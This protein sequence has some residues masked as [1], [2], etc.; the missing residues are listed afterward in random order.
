MAHHD[1]GGAAAYHESPVGGGA[2]VLHYSSSSS[3]RRPAKPKHSKDMIERF[4]QGEKKKAEYQELGL[5]GT[6]SF[7]KVYKA[8]QRGNLRLVAMKYIAKGDR[9]EDGLASLRAEIKIM[10]EVRHPNVVELLDWFETEKHFCIVMEYCEGDL[11][12]ILKVDETLPEDEIQRVAIGLVSA[13]EYLHKNRIVHRDLKPQNVLIAPDGAVKLCDFGFARSMG[14]ASLIKSFKGT[15]LYMA[16]ELLG[17]KAYNCLVDIWSLGVILYE[18]KYGEVP[19]KSDQYAELCQMVARQAVRFPPASM[20]PGSSLSAHRKRVRHISD[21]FRH[22]LASMLVKTRKQRIGWPALGCHPFL[23]DKTIPSSKDDIPVG[24]RRDERPPPAYM[25]FRRRCPPVVYSAQMEA[26]FDTATFDMRVEQYKGRGVEFMDHCSAIMAAQQEG[27]LVD[28]DD[29]AHDG[30]HDDG[31]GGDDIQHVQE[32]DEQERDKGQQ[33]TAVSERLQHV[34]QEK[35]QQNVDVGKAGTDNK[36]GTAT[37]AQHAASGDARQQKTPHV[38]SGPNDGEGAAVLDGV[39]DTSTSGGA[40]SESGGGATPICDDCWTRWI[41]EG[42]GITQCEALRGS[43]EFGRHLLSMIDVWNAANFSQRC[44]DIMEGTWSRVVAVVEAVAAVESGVSGKR[45]VL[46]MAVPDGPVLPFLF[47]M[48]GVCVQM[49]QHRV[50]PQEGQQQQQQD[51]ERRAHMGRRQHERV[52]QC[53]KSLMHAVSTIIRTIC[54]HVSPYCHPGRT[55]P[56]PLVDKLTSCVKVTVNGIRITRCL[57]E[58]IADQMPRLVAQPSDAGGSGADALAEGKEASALGVLHMSCRALAE[59]GRLSSMCMSSGFFPL[60]RNCHRSRYQSGRV[61]T[62]SASSITAT[63]GGAMGAQEAGAALVNELLP[64]YCGLLDDGTLINVTASLLRVLFVAGAGHTGSV[65]GDMPS[66]VARALAAILRCA[67]IRDPLFDRARG[68]VSGLMFRSVVKSARYRLIAS[69]VRCG[70][71]YITCCTEFAASVVAMLLNMVFQQHTSSADTSRD[72]RSGRNQRFD[73]LTAL[74]VNERAHVI[75]HALSVGTQQSV[76]LELLCVLNV[77]QVSNIVGRGRLPP[78]LLR[79]ICHVCLTTIEGIGVR[80]AQ[81]K[82]APYDQSHDLTSERHHVSSALG[83][84]CTSD[85]VLCLVLTVFEFAHAMLVE[86]GGDD[87]DVKDVMVSSKW[88]HGARLIP[89]WITACLGASSMS[90]ASGGGQKDRRG[91]RSRPST[92]GGPTGTS[93]AS[94]SRGGGVSQ[95]GRP[96]SSSGQRGIGGDLVATCMYFAAVWVSSLTW[97]AQGKRRSVHAHG[98]EKVSSSSALCAMVSEL[99]ACVAPHVSAIWKDFLNEARK[100]VIPVP[101]GA[102]ILTCNEHIGVASVVFLGAVAELGAVLRVASPAGQPGGTP[103]EGSDGGDGGDGGLE[104]DWTAALTAGVCT[105]F[106]IVTDLVPFFAADMFGACVEVLANASGG[107][108]RPVSQGDPMGASGRDGRN[109]RGQQRRSPL[110]DGDSGA[111]AGRSASTRTGEGYASEKSGTSRKQLVAP[112]IHDLVPLLG[113]ILS[114]LCATVKV[115]DTTY[116]SYVMGMDVV[117]GT[118]VEDAIVPHA[119]CTGALFGILNNESRL[120]D[121][122]VA[123]ER[124]WRNGLL[125]V[126]FFPS[127]FVAKRCASQRAPWYDGHDSGVAL[128]WYVQCS[129]LHSGVPQDALRGSM[130]VSGN[131][132]NNSGQDVGNRVSNRTSASSSSSPAQAQFADAHGTVASVTPVCLWHEDARHQQRHRTSGRDVPV[133]AQLSVV[134]FGLSC[135]RSSHTTENLV[136]DLLSSVGPTVGMLAH[137]LE[138]MFVRMVGCV[139]IVKRLSQQA[140]NKAQQEHLR[141]SGARIWFRVLERCL[142]QCRAYFQPASPCDAIGFIA[143][144]MS[145][146]VGRCSDVQT[147]MG[148]LGARRQIWVGHDGYRCEPSSLIEGASSESGW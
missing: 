121:A 95:S 21:S 27:T 101:T 61:T 31:V 124:R 56:L 79:A 2:P 120:Y 106:G 93:A 36:E 17:G 132:V 69:E 80:E 98:E 52:Q 118:L 83:N 6:G 24:G 74:H 40:G 20:A 29:D 34:A 46:D 60:L 78:P 64:V 97:A 84:R 137:T 135:G 123:V 115:C 88:Q 63:G 77:I 141:R 82:G 65:P 96:G 109:S 32:K 58:W 38:V 11:R 57:L 105:G 39:L 91:S 13:L 113:R 73:V 126:A 119:T 102:S 30:H 55:L 75:W 104:H 37:S 130:T 19:F 28:V 122:F 100:S 85:V 146:A 134:R 26:P 16:P 5:L 116:F 35:V 99:W 8:R 147:L 62:A 90:D 22:F 114:V 45:E 92:T 125:P 94:M 66:I 111:G 59:I 71:Y 128:W 33:E 138:C 144:Y 47:D 131:S 18:L 1:G 117:N 14:H 103:R 53:I 42:L 49:V 89:G 129:V 7:G 41:A 51:N 136:R 4:Q 143:A 108:S 9:K 23:T 110:R 87:A 133:T 70:K 76:C 25:R 54:K 3:R 10:S 72:A 140:A 107:L 68:S 112:W 86:H 12:E 67:F 142:E 145:D 15:P 81:Q 127:S 48:A 50:A 148:P 44:Q 43:E 139:N